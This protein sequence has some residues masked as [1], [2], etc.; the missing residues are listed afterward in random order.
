MLSDL[1]WVRDSS[2]PLSLCFPLFLFPKFQ[3]YPVTFSFHLRERWH[4]CQAG[5]RQVGDMA[6]GSRCK[7]WRGRLAGFQ[8]LHSPYGQEPFTEALFH[9]TRPYFLAFFS[10]HCPQGHVPIYFRWHIFPIAW[11]LPHICEH[12]HSVRTQRS[13]QFNHRIPIIN[14]T[15]CHIFKEFN[16]MVE[17]HWVNPAPVPLINRS[18]GWSNP[19][20]PP[21]F[22]V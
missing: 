5:L 10:P 8:H 3:F 19:R 18:V 7:T 2:F 17:S 21:P 11:S 6:A 20:L 22:Q 16:L 15:S 4:T 1:F 12:L 14:C 13:L 9:R